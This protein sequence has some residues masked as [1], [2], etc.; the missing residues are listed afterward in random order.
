MKQYHY[1]L[2]DYILRIVPRNVREMYNDTKV[3]ND[4]PDVQTGITTSI[5][6]RLWILE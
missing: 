3:A 5:V 2:R 4:I 6:S 1:G